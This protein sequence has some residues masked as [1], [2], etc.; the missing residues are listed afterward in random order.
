MT[1]PGFIVL[2]LLMGASIAF[3]ARLQIRALQRSVPYNRYLNALLLLEVLLVVPAGIYFAAFYPDWSWMYLVD[4]RN[5]PTGLSVMAIASYPVAAALGYLVGYFSARC[6]SD[7]VTVIF[8]LFVAFS[9]VMLFVMSGDKVSS[10]GTYEQ[11]HRNVGL[12]SFASTSLLPSTFLAVAC[13]C[14][15]WGHLLYRFSREGRLTSTSHA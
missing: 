6:A 14:A 12:K 13:F 8:L 7:W 9:L 1:I 5:L 2:S 3:S 15:S 11:Y 4:A 10:L